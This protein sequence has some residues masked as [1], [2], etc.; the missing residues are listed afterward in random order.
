MGTQADDCQ[1]DRVFVKYDMM[2]IF[3]RIHT[4][5]D[6][7]NHTIYAVALKP[8][9]APHID[10]STG[11][12]TLIN[13]T[14]YYYVGGRVYLNLQYFSIRRKKYF[15]ST[16]LGA[17]LT[18]TAHLGFSGIGPKKRRWRWA[19]KRNYMH[20]TEG[21]N[22]QNQIPQKTTQLMYILWFTDDDN[23]DSEVTK[24]SIQH[25]RTCK[26]VF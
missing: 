10:W 6:T 4:E 13:G 1:G 21:V 18:N 2:D 11:A 8:A 25:L 7:V 24:V 15:F 14:H 23:T 20:V 9:M 22:F 5:K 17:V 26:Q 16:N 12:L 19:F 3:W